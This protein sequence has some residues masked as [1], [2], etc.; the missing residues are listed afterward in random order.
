[1]DSASLQLA[2]RL[3]SPQDITALKSGKTSRRVFLSSSNPTQKRERVNYTLPEYNELDYRI[4]TALSGEGQI[5]INGKART[6]RRGDSIPVGPGD[7]Q[8]MINDGQAPLIAE[9]RPENPRYW[10]PDKMFM[11]LSKGKFVA[12]NDAWFELVLPL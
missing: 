1:M 11:E 7:R 6:F 4:I 10:H 9:I 2:K 12:G 8:R 5:E 3:Y